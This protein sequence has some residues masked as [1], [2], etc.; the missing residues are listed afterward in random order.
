[1]DESEEPLDLRITNRNSSNVLT[2]YKTAYKRM[3]RRPTV[4]ELE[5][6]SFIRKLTYELLD[7]DLAITQQ[8]QEHLNEIEKACKQ[9]F[10]QFDSRQIRSIVRAQLKLYRRNLKKI[11]QKISPICQ[12]QLSFEVNTSMPSRYVHIAPLQ[13]TAITSLSSVSSI[14]RSVSNDKTVFQHQ[15]NNL[16]TPKLNN[17]QVK[18]PI[19]SEL[20]TFIQR[21]NEA[22]TTTV[23][24]EERS[25]KYQVTN[26]IDIQSFKFLDNLST[27][28]EVMNVIS[29]ADIE[30]C[31][32]NAL[33][34]TNW[35]I[36]VVPHTT[37]PTVSTSITS[38]S[39]SSTENTVTSL[40]SLSLRT[41]ANHL[42]QTARLYEIFSLTDQIINRQQL[43]ISNPQIPNSMSHG[44]YYST[45]PKNLLTSPLNLEYKPFKTSLQPKKM[46]SRNS[47]LMDIKYD[48][49]NS[50]IS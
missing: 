50:H 17:Q 22:H 38:Q 28:C 5:F 44:V 14:N 31:S 27:G 4:K 11:K 49:D 2:K 43:F 41:S 9:S 19:N 8:S 40:L 24:N 23:K 37:T 1:M 26:D 42:I 39:I 16:L 34:R 6:G 12:S 20:N 3:K 35:I 30:K 10:P 15:L 48:I 21:G 7:P 13:P 18:S 46:C 36:P 45:E 25:S 29:Q 33:D 47:S 32:T